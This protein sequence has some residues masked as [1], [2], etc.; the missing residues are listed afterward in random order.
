MTLED[1]LLAQF[2]HAEGRT[3]WLERKVEGLASDTRQTQS[4]KAERR[5]VVV[6]LSQLASI[7]NH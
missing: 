6:Y 2:I 3:L 5:S 4:Y 1:V 7:E